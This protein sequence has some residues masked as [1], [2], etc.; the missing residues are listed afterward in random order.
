M[1]KCKRFGLICMLLGLVFL[2]GG[3]AYGEVLFPDG[4]MVKAKCAACHKPDAQGKLEVLENTRKTT[5]EWIVVV[6]RMMRLNSLALEKENFH[7]VIK[8]LSSKLCLSPKEMAAVA[9]LNSDEN[10]Q[11]REIP[12]NKEEER[13]FISCVRCHTYG[14]IASHKMTKDQWAETRIMHLGYYPTV[15]GQMREL[16]WI[17]ES[18]ALIEPVAKLF[19]FDNPEWKEWMQKRK[20]QDLSGEWTVAGYQPGKGYYE[21]SYVIKAD[22]KA[23]KDEYVIEKN[24]HYENGT[25]VKMS[26]SGTLYSGFHLRYA[27]PATANAGAVEGVFDLDAENMNF[28]GKWWSVVQD[29]NAYGN[30]MFA[31]SGGTAK[32]IC[33]YP[34]ALKTQQSSKLTL[35]GVNLPSIKA[36]DIT[37]SKPG[38]TVTKV[39]QAGASKI[40][41]DVNVKKEAGSGIVGLKVK[42][43]A[44]DNALKV[45]GKIDAIRVLREI[46][47]ARVSSGA[48]YPAQGVQ[49]VA[50]AINAGPDGKVGTDDDLVLNPVD[51]KWSLAEEKTREGDDDL[52]YLTTDVKNGLYKPITTYAPIMSRAQHAEGIGL[53]RIK[54]SYNK[55][56][57]SSRL[58]VT[59]P[60]FIT[61][62]K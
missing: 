29:T 35:I 55:L 5:E 50:R 34:E 49:F 3:P 11:Y 26:G 38:I 36:A 25:S 15:V 41:C 10:S 47:R 32:V 13:I 6:D 4:S 2:L 12:K 16:D 28:S 17:E 21:G 14:K 22:A 18:K 54:A 37:F 8:E 58:A 43:V 45:Y 56:E 19:P 46:G 51:A 60:D 59:V 62:L 9:Y 57:G 27:L 30:E 52:K 1:R 61:H 53:I 42:D 23:G 31:K 33:A 48:A 39:E 20:D 7:P 24:V 44:Y 40:V